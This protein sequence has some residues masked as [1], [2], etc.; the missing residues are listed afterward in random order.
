[1]KITL[2]Q[3]N[4]NQGLTTCSRFVASRP[5]LPILANILLKT[6]NGRL[7]LSA[8][9][10]EM[11]VNIWVGGKIEK[12]GEIT[13]SAKVINEFVSSLPPEKVSIELKENNLL[14]SSPFSKSIFPTIAAADFPKIPGFPKKTALSLPLGLFSEC[15]TQVAFAAATD[16][17]RPVLTG[18]LLKSENKD[19]S[20]VATD[21]YRLSV[22]KIS[23]IQYPISN[24]IIIPARALMEVSRIKS[25]E[26][27]GEDKKEKKEGVLQIGLTE[28]ENQIVFALPDL[29]L[30]SRLI[31]GEFPE[32]EK[33]IPTE[34]KT[35]LVF[36]R[37]EFL[38]AVRI[39]SI[40]AR[41]SANIVKLKT[42]K[43]KLKISANAPQV[44][45]NESVLEAKIQGEEQE[46]AFNF[47]FLLDFLN[48]ISAEQVSLEMTGPLNPGVFK[49][50]GDDSFLHIIMPVRVQ[51]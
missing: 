6:K 31:E 32:F 39:A 17:G 42:E 18:V 12:E 19:V 8:T 7:K 45:E 2:L 35:K 10:L 26:G 15:V 25:N 21:G 40:F 16:E 29:E 3:E 34:T 27:E 11:G 20:L 50:V 4:L 47:R 1:M 33:I 28:K 14:V 30:S 9:D 46:I 22:K 49:P 41:E 13:V 43:G 23:N 38:R 44:G 51:S 5:Q 37:E 48:S 36:D 24:A